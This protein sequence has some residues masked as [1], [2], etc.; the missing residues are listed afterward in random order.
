MNG[1]FGCMT[2][3][4][5]EA[6]DWPS[7]Q[8]TAF[9]TKDCLCTLNC[10]NFVW[11]KRVNWRWCY[12]YKKYKHVNNVQCIIFPAHQETC[13]SIWSQD[14][15]RKA[16]TYLWSSSKSLSVEGICEDKNFFYK[17]SVWTLD[18][19]HETGILSLIIGW[20]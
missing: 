15:H 18:L 5:L 9:Y 17:H 10:V 1:T 14:E 13:A 7:S 4:S 8:S 11:L 3:T 19:G 6:V 12:T 16:Q 20:P 2:P